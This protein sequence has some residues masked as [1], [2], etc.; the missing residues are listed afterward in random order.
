MSANLSIKTPSLLKFVSIRRFNHDQKTRHG[1]Q[2]IKVSENPENP[3][4]VNGWVDLG[5][6]F[7]ISGDILIM[8]QEKKK[9][10]LDRMCYDRV[11]F[12]GVNLNLFE[13]WKGKISK[14]I[15]LP[16][17][18][19]KKG[20]GDLAGP[21]KLM[22]NGL[23]TVLKLKGSGFEFPIYGSYDDKVQGCNFN[24]HVNVAVVGSGYA[25]RYHNATG[26]HQLR[27]PQTAN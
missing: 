22:W 21:W 1:P 12:D 15:D 24:S 25:I 20:E 23:Q 18:D 26:W 11:P 27:V 7:L 8:D 19:P 6:Y 3:R 17:W 13:Q 9:G 5:D 10:I 14:H 4:S 2:G 16:N